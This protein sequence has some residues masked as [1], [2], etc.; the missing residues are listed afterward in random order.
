MKGNGLI[1]GCPFCSNIPEI[2]H[3]HGGGPQK[4]MVS[5]TSD[6]CPVGPM[7]TGPTRSKAIQTW[8]SRKLPLVT[9]AALVGSVMAVYTEIG[10]AHV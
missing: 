10:R 1:Y 4:T 3:W 9:R 8:N 7:V 6:D 2:H 5:C